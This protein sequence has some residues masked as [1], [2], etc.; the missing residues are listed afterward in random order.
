MK[1]IQAA[2]V[3]LAII[4]GAS[5][6]IGASLYNSNQQLTAKLD[7][8]NQSYSKLNAGLDALNQSYNLLL[9]F[10]GNSAMTT[11]ATLGLSFSMAL[12]TTILQSGQGISITINELNLLDGF[13]NI[14]ASN[15]WAYSSYQ[16]SAPC[17]SMN[18][19]NL[20][21]AVAIVPGY[22]TSSNLQEVASL[23]IYYDPS[24]IGPIYCVFIGLPT[25]YDFYP[26]SE[27]SVVHTSAEISGMLN[28]S[29]ST[30]LV[31]SGYYNST[32]PPII[33]QSSNDSLNQ[34]ITTIPLNN[35]TLF[36]DPAQS[37]LVSFQPGIYTVIG[38][39]EWGQL[40]VLHF[41]VFEK[42]M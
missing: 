22:Y 7:T 32:D 16:S 10:R 3:V 35:M 5:I 21:F 24:S 27:N 30:T 39:D 19:Y 23:P 1:P 17:S 41:A 25:E 28:E 36:P 8:L 37:E 18:L 12:N 42:T 33:N 2:I 11:N 38:G 15:N 40:I 34:N 9:G 4:L 14:T 20:P 29:T 13:N 6:A 31:F 26:L